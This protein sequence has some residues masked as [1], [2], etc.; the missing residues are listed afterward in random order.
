M[1]CLWKS[2]DNLGESVPPWRST[3][4]IRV[5]GKCHNSPSPPPSSTYVFFSPTFSMK[6][7]N[8]RDYDEG[9]WL[10]PDLLFSCPRFT[11]LFCFLA[12]E[13]CMLPSDAGDGHDNLTRW[14][15]D[16]EKHY[17]RPFTYSGC[18]G[19]SNNFLSKTDCKNACMLIGKTHVPS[20]L[21]SLLNY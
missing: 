11:F 7:S 3:Q 15:F 14:Y 16:S 1:L 19:N 10:E 9:L 21:R 8:I 13:P 20:S 2:T 12:S 5:G 17:C 18:H 4:V 6:S